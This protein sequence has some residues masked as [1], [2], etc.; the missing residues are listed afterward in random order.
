MSLGDPRLRTRQTKKG[1]LRKRPRQQVRLIH[2]SISIQPMS[3]E[4]KAP[5]SASRPR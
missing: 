1:L 4:E 5:F 2:H 3:S